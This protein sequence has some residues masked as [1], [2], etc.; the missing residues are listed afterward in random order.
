[1]SDKSLNPRTYFDVELDNKPIGRITFE[2]YADIVPKTAE[3]FRSLC[4]GDKGAGP[5]TGVALHYKGCPFHRIIKGFMIQGGDFS[6]RNG[7][8]GESIYGKKFAD[9]NFKY[10]HDQ[11]GLLSMA[12]AGPNT[13]G[14][15]F[16]IT[17]V[18]TPHLD[19]K[20]VVFGR[21]ISGMEVVRQIENTM[22]DPEDH[23]PYAN[24]IIKS[25]G[26]LVLQKAFEPKQEKPG[27]DSSSSSESSEEDEKTKEKKRKKKEK[28]ERKRQ[29]Q[30]AKRAKKEQKDKEK[31]EEYQK[32]QELLTENKPKENRP[33]SPPRTTV[34]G[35]KSFKGRGR[36]KL[37]DENGTHEDEEYDEKYKERERKR[38]LEGNK[39]SNRYRSSH[40]DRDVR[41]SRDER[42]YE[43]RHR[44]RINDSHFQKEGDRSYSSHRHSPRRYDRDRS[45]RS[46][47]LYKSRDKSA[48][49]ER[50]SGEKRDKRDD[51]KRDKKRRW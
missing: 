43:E 49:P 44:D 26:E 15:Q 17:T 39:Y 48:S 22:V 38:Y 16:F 10:K 23:L 21:V 30:E 45:P 14:S 35:G 12:N 37:D 1:M 41:H 42:F 32:L 36:I 31:Y 18:K 33:K 7:T 40:D 24:V 34:I 3:N 46:K 51:Y 4:T 2:L 50:Y 28:K 9:E 20:H 5:N 13:N 6:K 19:G 8:G 29:K 25:C 47:D 27:E 11:P